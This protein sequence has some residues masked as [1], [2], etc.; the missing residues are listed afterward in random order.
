MAGGGLSFDLMDQL[1]FYGAYHSH[2]VNKG[3]R[4]YVVAMAAAVGGGVVF[5]GAFCTCCRPRPLLGPVTHA[6]PKKTHNTTPTKAIHF[7][8]V[9]A[10]VWATLVWLAGFGPLAPL[11]AW[12]PLTAL[13]QALPPWLARCVLFW[14]FGGGG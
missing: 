5:F 13:V 6:L 4:V 8:F 12:G 11:P 7:V 2:P 9:P 3:A 14:R 1:A 10:I